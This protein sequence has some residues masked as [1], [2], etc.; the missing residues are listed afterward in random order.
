MRSLIRF[1]DLKHGVFIVDALG[2]ASSTKIK[3]V[4]NR[5]HV[6]DTG[7]WS[8]VAA[9]TGDSLMALYL[10]IG[11]FTIHIFSEKFFERCIAEIF[12]FFRYNF[13]NLSQTLHC[14]ETSTRTLL[15]R[16]TLFVDFATLTLVA[17][18]LLFDTF[19]TDQFTI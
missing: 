16:A 10:L 6:P 14:K 2:F 5:A 12:N 17:S 19:F 9:I 8:H 1:S 15:T 11:I 3:I 7:N 13:Y 4:A 18:H